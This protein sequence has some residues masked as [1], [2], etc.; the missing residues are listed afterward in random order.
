MN[1]LSLESFIPPQIQNNNS[2]CLLSKEIE[3]FP[4]TQIFNPYIFAS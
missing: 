1:G 3:T 2:V 4:Q